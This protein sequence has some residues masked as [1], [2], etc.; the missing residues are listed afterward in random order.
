[1]EYKMLST[2]RL[3]WNKHQTQMLTCLLFAKWNECFAESSQDFE[4]LLGISSSSTNTQRRASHQSSLQVKIYSAQYVKHF[5]KAWPT[6]E[7]GTVLYQETSYTGKV[8][9]GTSPLA[10]RYIMALDILSISVKPF[11]Q[12]ETQPASSKQPFAEPAFSKEHFYEI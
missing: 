9:Q 6:A 10:S 8:S 5:S 4:V 11:G 7:C 2:L 12:T 3:C 1:M